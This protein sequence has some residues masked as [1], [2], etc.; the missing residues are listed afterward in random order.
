MATFAKNDKGIIEGFVAL[1][2]LFR[3]GQSGL[4]PML[5]GAYVRLRWSRKSSWP[6][7][8]RTKTTGGSQNGCCV[9]A[10]GDYCLLIVSQGVKMRLPYHF[11]AYSMPVT[12]RLA[13]TSVTTV[14][15]SE[16]TR[17][18][19]YLA[20]AY[21]GLIVYASLYPFA[22]WRDVGLPVFSFL[23]AAWPRYWTV[24]DLTVNVLVY[25]PLGF[26]STLALQRLPAR[27]LAALLA[28]LLAALLSFCL[29]VLQTWLPSRVPSN[30][31]LACNAL[32]GAIGAVL[33]LCYGMRL[34]ERFA[35]L[36]YSLLVHKPHAE[37]GL[38]LV[39]LWL[40]TQLS[41]ET[42]LFGAGDL[43]RLLEIPPAM[44]YEA[45]S[46]FALETG[47]IVSN[48]I[49]IGLIAREL[50]A[51]RKPP[52]LA[53]LVFFLL[54]LAIR[55]LAAAI[56]V[57]PSHAF[58]WLTPGAG[59]GLMIG[60]AALCLLLLL[61]PSLR[62]A[63]AGLA[64]MAGTVLVNVAPP[65]PYSAVAMATWGQGHFL[66]FN[67]LTRLS[68]SIWPFLVLPYMTWLGRRL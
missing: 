62:V 11:L 16:T 64:L 17:L 21:G 3:A 25:L 44:P 1:F 26:L 10:M 47:I 15:A 4:L 34:F 27:W 8:E 5:G 63:I 13:K 22:N 12:D 38:V 54:A 50:L 46:F 57:D 40:L 36:Q 39:G 53:L 14:V 65:N 35:R 29:E 23:D 61:P 67:G 49:A 30:L 55:T 51:A 41:P 66:N 37:L 58:I 68:A 33:A 43:R 24:F 59:L 18:P 60:G 48:M 56:L 32:G 45:P 6:V 2:L 20:L 7:D 28:F 52:Y 31:D 9:I 42:I 19:C